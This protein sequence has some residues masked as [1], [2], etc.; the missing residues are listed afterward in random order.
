MS[1]LVIDDQEGLRRSLCAYLEDMDYE[2]LEAADG[3]LGL[4]VLDTHLPD[5]EAVIVDLNMPVMDGYAFLAHA[6]KRAPDL[7]TIVLSGVGVVDDA[8][9]AMRAGAWDFITKPLHDFNILQLTLDKVLERARLLREN[10]AYQQRLESMV[11]ERTAE[12]ERTRRQIIQRLSRAAEYKDNETGMHVIRVGEISA[13]LG[14][15]LGLPEDRCD[16][17]RQ[18]APLHDVGKI[19]IPDSILL[20]PGALDSG[21]WELMRRHC[22]FGCELLGPLERGEARA[23]C[24][25]HRVAQEDEGN[26]FLAL[27]RTL[28]L[29]HHERWDGTGY[30]FGLPGPD[31]PLEAR[32]VSLVDVYDALRSE[33]PY[34]RPF[35]REECRDAIAAGSGTQFDPAVVRAFLDNL[36]AIEAIRERWVG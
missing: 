33:R 22:S 5:V 36:D 14:R 19:G 12:I 20:K 26:P 30:P 9:R 28:A 29:L 23:S 35:S 8:I 1:V 27:A 11:R 10:R 13:L 18:C 16:M 17:L 32:I 2:T 15:A 3:R 21:E 31:V 6:S 7:P 24:T 25:S 4:E 34:K